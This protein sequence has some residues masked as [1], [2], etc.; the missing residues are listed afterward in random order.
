MEARS[1]FEAEP[2]DLFDDGARAANGAGRSVE[3]R[4]KSVPG[5]LDFAATEA[6][7]LATHDRMVLVQQ[8]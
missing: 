8:G 2:L 4:E 5:C 1:H 7:E 3:G 6:G